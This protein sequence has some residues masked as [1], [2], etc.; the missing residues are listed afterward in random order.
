MELESVLRQLRAFPFIFTYGGLCFED[1]KYD[2][3]ESLN[4][5]RTNLTRTLP[6]LQTVVS[7]EDTILM[8]IQ[9]SDD[10]YMSYAI[11]DIQ[12]KAKDFKNKPMSIGYREGYIMNYLTLELAEYARH[13]WRA[14]ETSSY[15][16]NTIPPFFTV[17]FPRSIFLDPEAHMKW[18][19]PYRS[20]EYI[21]DHTLYNTLPGAGFVVG[22]HGENVST[23]WN[24][25]YKGRI[26]EGDEKEKVLIQSGLYKVE[27][28]KLQVDKK[29][30]VENKIVKY[31]PKPLKRMYVRMV[32]PGIGSAINDYNYFNL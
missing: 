7:Q 13:D 18:T 3:P 1:D 22:T 32:S 17:V 20:H 5:L 6:Y 10:M 8:T 16:T 29:R 28:L 14:D 12:E 24:H 15:T 19:G 31:L 23:T 30:Q 4:R 25:R 11:H 2:R 21:G 26:L 27:P 9:P